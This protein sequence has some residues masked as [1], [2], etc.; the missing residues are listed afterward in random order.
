MQ[1]YKI[2][3]DAE[4]QLSNGYGI[5]AEELF[6]GS[7]TLLGKSLFGRYNVKK[8]KILLRACRRLFGGSR[9]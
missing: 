3:I 2:K 4:I 9:F 6:I 7:Q 1:A 5:K 8:T